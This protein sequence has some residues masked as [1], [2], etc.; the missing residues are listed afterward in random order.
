MNSKYIFITGGVVSSLGKGITAASLGRILKQKNIKI[1]MQKFDPYINVDPG[2]MSPYQH[3]EV[4]VTSDGAET[5]L[6]LGHYER[7]ID[8]NLTRDSNIT[9][10]KVY[11]TVLKKERDGFYEGKT[12]Q[13]VPHVTDEIK[14][15]IFNSAINSKADVIITEIGGTVGDIESL[16]FI[17]AIRQ[18]KNEKGHENVIVIH[19]TLIPYL[20]SVGEFKTKPSQHSVKEILSL[21]IQPDILVCRS[22]TMPPDH[23][24]DKLSLFC[25]IKRSHVLAIPDCDNIYKVP[26]SLEQQK[27]DEVVSELLKLNKTKPDMSEWHAIVKK[28]DNINQEVTVGIV[29]KYSNLSDAY[30]SVI[31]S[32]KIAGYSLNTKVNYKIINAESLDSKNIN[33]MLSPFQ[34][35]IVPGGFGNRGVEGKI[36]A[37]NYTRVNKVPFLGLCLGMQLACIEYA[38]NVCNLQDANSTEFNEKTKNPIFDLLRGKNKNDQIGGTLRLGNYPTTLI[39]DSLAKSLYKQTIIIERHRHRYEFNNSYKTLLAKNGLIFSGIYNKEDLV[40]VIELPK[41]VHPFFIASQFHPEFTS[42]INKPNPLFLGLIK[43]II[44]K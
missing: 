15:H 9:A 11:Q 31:E 22:E 41:E 1:F 7:F 21:G 43:S 4:Y 42:R 13:V 3:G 35:I 37:I 40:E 36:N 5:D 30:L 32:L 18:V 29:A 26:L 2:T 44:K 28:L 14:K 33:S 24:F 12:V 6:D 38:R 8:E 19:T 39:N 23:I 34:A 10:G 16:A 17:E 25:N 20:H 27:I